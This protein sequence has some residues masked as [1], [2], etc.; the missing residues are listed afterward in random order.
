MSQTQ[1]KPNQ[2]KRKLR[3]GEVSLGTWVTIANSD[4]AEILAN[5]GMDWLVF[6]TE[7]APLSIETI[8]GMI[9]GT[10]GTDTVPLVRVAGNDMVLIKRALDIGSYGVIVPLVNTVDDAKKAVSY[11]RYPPKGVR[12]VGPR[13]CSVYGIRT[14]EYFRW[15]DE[16]I[17]TIVQVETA[18]AVSNID[19]IM[20]VEGVDACFIGPND[21]STSLGNRG[22]QTDPRYIKAVE[23][24]LDASRKHS[25]PV[26]TM[27]YDANEVRLAL[28]R[29]FKF[30]SLSADFR[31]LIRGA[32]FMLDAGNVK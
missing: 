28:S 13:R 25:V 16:E 30:I 20:S 10:S 19:D 12:G 15:A 9:Q 18:E 6:D 1:M 17:I 8:E 3:N 24:V 26:G 21:L 23:R 31:H 11:T 2:V 7:H 4:V 22:D 32:K 29:G 5:I 14:Q 27:T